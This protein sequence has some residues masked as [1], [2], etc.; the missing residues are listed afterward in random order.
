MKKIC[1]E[2]PLEVGKWTEAVQAGF[3]AIGQDAAVHYHNGAD[4]LSK[5]SNRLHFFLRRTGLPGL[6]V[7]WKQISNHRVQAMV[8]R[9]RCEVLVSL[10]GLIDEE[11]VQALRKIN[12]RIR[13]I[14]WCAQQV[15]DQEQITSIKEAAD[16][17]DVVALPYL[18]DCEML[19]SRESLPATFLPFAA[20]PVQ[21]RVKMGSKAYKKFSKEVIL[22]GDYSQ[23]QEDLLC[24]VSE[25]LGQAVH[26]WG[27]GWSDNQWITAHGPLYPPQ[28][29][30]AFAAARIVLNLHGENCREHNGLNPK[31]F[32]IAAV[33]GFQITED[34]PF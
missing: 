25:A 32:Q 26:V 20:C 12:P 11:T 28:S 16:L 34:Q 13:I 14:Y 1:I 2:G 9:H 8:R 21:H 17:A 18:G 6:T 5:I 29:L 24:R 4:T 33:G 19:S 15:R 3:K 30:Q 27:Q 23:Y 31:F 22:I 10:H 7:T